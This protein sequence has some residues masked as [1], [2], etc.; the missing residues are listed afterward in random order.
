M[1]VVEHCWPLVFNNVMLNLIQHLTAS[2]CSNRNRLWAKNGV[3][4][5]QAALKNAFFIPFAKK[6][7]RFCKVDDE[8]T[9]Y[10]SNK[11]GFSLRFCI[12]VFAKNVMYQQQKREW[13]AGNIRKKDSL[14][15]ESLF[16]CGAYGTRTR[17]PMR[18]RHVF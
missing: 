4:W 2:L 10:V 9:Y 7:Q 13:G 1:T 3:R 8:I 5:H 17:D 16:C 6:M 14:L 15:E 18:D 11:Y 12:F